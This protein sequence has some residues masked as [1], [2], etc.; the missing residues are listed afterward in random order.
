M[1][2]D[3]VLSLNSSWQAIGVKSVRAA[4][5]KMNAEKKIAGEEPA[6][7]LDIQYDMKIVTDDDGND[8][9]VVDYSNIISYNPVTWDEWI[10]LPVEDHHLY[11][12]HG[13]DKKI[14]VPTVI[15]NKNYNKMPLYEKRFTKNAIFERDKATCQYSGKKLSKK[16]ASVDHVIPKNRGG[17][18]TWENVVL[19]DREINSWKSN[20]LNK[21]IGLK[22]IG[23]IPDK[24]KA[25]PKCAMIKNPHEVIDWFPFLLNKN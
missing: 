2:L 12:S 3:L 13:R 4:I 22:L 7:A 18:N 24:P 25:V 1:T 23:K 8:Q 10:E 21:E 5:I 14:R 6:F 17:K 16:T 19:C 15:I 11:I 20:R 9:I